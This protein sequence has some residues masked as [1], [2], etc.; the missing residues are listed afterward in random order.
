MIIFKS[1]WLYAIGIFVIYN[2]LTNKIYY[3]IIPIVLK[4]G[5][6]LL[7]WEYILTCL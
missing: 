5:G 2:Y 3:N 7:E 6:E 1:L 4:T